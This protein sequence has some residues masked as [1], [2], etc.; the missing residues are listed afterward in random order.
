[1][2]V[3]ERFARY[4]ALVMTP[5]MGSMRAL[6]L[7]GVITNAVIMSTGEAVRLSQSGLGCPDWPKCTVRSLVAARSAGQSTANTW[8]EFGNRLLNV[9]LFVVAV[10]AFVAAWRYRENGRARK[11]LLWLAGSLPG[12]IVAQ[13]VLGGILVLAHLNPVLVSA[14]FLLSIGIVAAAVVFYVRCAEGDG[15]VRTIVRRDLRLMAALLVAVTVVMEAAGTVVTGTGPH[16]GSADVARYHLPLVGVTQFHAD[17]GWFLSALAI[18]TLIGVRFGSTPLRTVRLAWL[19]FTL[20]MVQG[21][22]GYTQYFSHL[23]AGLV[24]VHAST[25]VLIWIVVLLLYLSTRERVSTAQ[26]G[27]TL[28][29]E[30]AAVPATPA[31]TRTSS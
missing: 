31:R 23:P 19:T 16:A 26:N 10:L 8:I 27:E 29:G 24:W 30:T 15:P 12:G 25:A 20:L 3:R 11:D 4:Y 1:M 6:A 28:P 5:T 17:I 22:I 13:A 2:G 9:P 18:G 21:A 14:H 7:G